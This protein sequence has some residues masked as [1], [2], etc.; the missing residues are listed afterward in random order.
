M[1]I[2]IITIAFNAQ[3]TI[4]AAVESVVSQRGDNFELEYIIVDG[5]STDCTLAA[6]EPHRES[7]STVISEPDQGLY[8]AMNK[9]VEAATGEFIGIL[10]A[11]DQYAH[12]AVLRN[13]AAC[14]LSSSADSLYGDLVYINEANEITRHWKS[15]GYRNGQFN[16]EGFLNGWMPP[17]PTFFLRKSAYE[18]HGLFNLQL[19]SAA[20]YELMLRMLFKHRVSTVHLP[21]VLV[22]MRTGG[23]SNASWSNRVRANRE[24]RMAWRLNGLSPRPWTLIAKPLRKLSQWWSNGENV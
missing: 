21:E 22:H 1:K 16:P 15:G 7:I 13:V 6:I 11:D 14:L 8:D 19:R 18:Q 4:A 12:D 24:D 17:H 2:S 20:D 23:V 5:A 10:N 9:G 3:A